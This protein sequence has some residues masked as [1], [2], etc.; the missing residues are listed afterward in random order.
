MAAAIQPGVLVAVILAAILLLA[1]LAT[2]GFLLF[3]RMKRSRTT[4]TV[5]PAANA[6]DNE[7]PYA[8]AS[9]DA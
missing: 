8:L 9:N 2:G 1:L 6:Q 4:G 5:S 3:K 7:H